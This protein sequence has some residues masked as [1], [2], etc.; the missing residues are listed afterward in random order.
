MTAGAH[1]GA[2]PF[3]RPGR[4]DARDDGRATCSA[5]RGC[6]SHD[7][8]GPDGTQ[9]LAPGRSRAMQTRQ[10]D[11][12]VLCRDGRRVGPRLR[13]LRHRPRASSSATTAAPSARPRSC[14]WCPRQ[15]V[16]VA[17]LT[18]GGDVFGSV[19]RRGRPRLLARAHRRDA[20]GAARHRRQSP[21]HVDASRLPRHLRRHDLRPPRQP[22]RRGPDLARPGRRR[23]SS[24]RSARS[25][26]ASSSSTT[27]RRLA[28]S[29]SRPTTAS[30]SSTRSSA[31]TATGRAQYVH[32][33]RVVSP[34]RLTSPPSPTPTA[35]RGTAH[36]A[37]PL[38]CRPGALPSPLTLAACGAE[39]RGVAGVSR[40]RTPTATPSPSLIGTDPG[41]LDPQASPG[42]ALFAARPVRLRLAGH[43]RRRS[44]EIEPQLATSWEVDG[45]T[46]TFDARRRTSPAPTARPSRPR[47][48][49]TTS[50]TSA[51]PRTRAPSSASS[52]RSAPRRADVAAAP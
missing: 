51:T 47:R 38:E 23:T 26:S 25:P 15:G 41:K 3:E 49:P 34:R 27:G 46:V 35:E 17:L 42:S 39:R 50:T 36:E 30:T 2:G 11:L 52:S 12:P 22:G 21:Q 20:P 24:P 6:T 43:R 40:Q 37:C 7:G 4:L 32:Y 33:G 13:A 44:G 28:S 18:N 16:A 1:V 45:T 48:W 19:Q 9:V 10:V 31:T 14:G 5:S 8:A 29:P